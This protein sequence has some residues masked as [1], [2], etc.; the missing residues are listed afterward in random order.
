MSNS[1]TCDGCEHYQPTYE[2]CG[3]LVG[4]LHCPDCDQAW[5]LS[6]GV[7][8]PMCSGFRQIVDLSECLGGKP[9]QSCP[10]KEEPEV[11]RVQGSLF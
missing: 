4:R 2:T 3:A 1:M 5:Q 10:G 9:S 8:C 7:G 11:V 6:D